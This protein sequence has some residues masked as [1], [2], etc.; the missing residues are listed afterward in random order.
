MPH[1]VHPDR[2]HGGTRTG[3]ERRGHRAHARAPGRTSR[4]GRNP[5]QRRALPPVGLAQPGAGCPLGV[6]GPHQGSGRPHVA[7]EVG[8][9]RPHPAAA[10]SPQ[11]HQRVPKLQRASCGSCDRTPFGQTT[12]PSSDHRTLNIDEIPASATP[13][14]SAES[15]TPHAHNLRPEQKL[16]WWHRKTT[17]VPSAVRWP[18]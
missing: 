17:C 3:T 9:S 7:S 6:A 11:V 14:T 13:L 4:L 1:H 8:T 16:A 10:A 12:R 15:A 5:A 18:V 2:R